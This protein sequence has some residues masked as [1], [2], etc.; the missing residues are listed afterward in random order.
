MFSTQME[1]YENEEQRQQTLS[2]TLG[3]KVLPD[4]SYL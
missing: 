2:V 4:T 3:M 1:M